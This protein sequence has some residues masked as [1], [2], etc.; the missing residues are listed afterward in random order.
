MNIS[1]IC[2]HNIISQSQANFS[3]LLFTGKEWTTNHGYSLWSKIK[4]QNQIQSK[5]YFCYTS[6]DRI[7][8]QNHHNIL[9]TITS[10][11]YIPFKIIHIQY[12]IYYHYSWQVM[13]CT[14]TKTEIIQLPFPSPHWAPR[15][16]AISVWT[17]SCSPFSISSCRC[18][19]C[20]NCSCCCCCHWRSSR[21]RCS[22]L[23]CSLACCCSSKSRAGS[24]ATV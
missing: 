13:R 5:M 16:E 14:S 15:C 6:I 1:G 8:K 24:S 7:Q 23:V 18:C 3:F 12:S 2:V 4:A 11:V 9:Y 17:R 21:N 20:I 22:S 10:I 19:C